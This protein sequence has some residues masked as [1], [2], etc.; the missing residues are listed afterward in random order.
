MRSMLLAGF[1]LALSGTTFLSAGQVILEEGK[2]EETNS[3]VACHGLKIIHDQRLSKSA[4]DRELDKMQRWGANI[5]N[6]RALLEYLTANFG[7]DKPV[8]VPKLT[9]DGTKTETTKKK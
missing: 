9:D 7:D 3:C 8:P 2:A 6:R 4:W 1:L 5:Q